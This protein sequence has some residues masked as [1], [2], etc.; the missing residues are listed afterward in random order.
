[1]G[2]EF[3]VINGAVGEARFQV[4]SDGERAESCGFCKFGFLKK[5]R[6]G[7]SSKNRRQSLDAKQCWVVC[8]TLNAFMNFL[9]CRDK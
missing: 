1:M 4:F 8:S 2:V 6:G 7:L 3:E 5:G 9:N